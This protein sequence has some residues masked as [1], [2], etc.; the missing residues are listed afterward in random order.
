ML[1]PMLRAY[2]T[3]TTWA[4]VIC[5]GGW[6]ATFFLMTRLP[7]P[8]EIRS[9]LYADPVQASITPPTP[10]SPVSSAPSPAPAPD[11][12]HFSYLGQ[13]ITVV[14]VADYTIAGLI[15]AHNDPGAWYS[16][17]YDHDKEDPNT[18]DICLLWG[19]LLKSPDYRSIS[20]SGDQW[21]CEHGALKTATPF[22]EGD[23]SQNHLLTESDAVRRQ[24]ANL[25]TGDQV[26][27]KGQLVN[28]TEPAWHGRFHNS[29]TTRG[30]TGGAG[31]EIILVNSVQLLDSHNAVWKTLHHLCLV[32]FTLA[33]AIRVFVFIFVPS[34]YTTEL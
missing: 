3:I 28:Y 24:I 14:P 20:Y 18:M 31:A 4:M 29:S 33:L 25:N 5:A 27:I 15:V 17:N 34:R 11:P 6:V 21:T 19:S 13:D 16:F 32:I 2:F 22:P 30:D 9:P 1:P 10:P 23:L 8:S 26:L 7:P 12:K